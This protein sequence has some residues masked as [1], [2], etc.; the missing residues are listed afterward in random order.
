[1][2]LLVSKVISFN[3]VILNYMCQSPD[4][5]WFAPLDLKSQVHVSYKYSKTCMHTF[6]DM[7]LYNLSLETNTPF[8]AY[9]VCSSLIE[10]KWSPRR[11]TINFHFKRPF[12]WF[13]STFGIIYM[14]SPYLNRLCHFSS[15]VAMLPYMHMLLNSSFDITRISFII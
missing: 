3:C 4:Y 7:L 6:R 12:K 8:Q 1:M 11:K 10:G 13:H 15:Y 2:L 5:R 14:S 9:H